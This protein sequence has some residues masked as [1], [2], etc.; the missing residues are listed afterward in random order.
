MKIFNEK[1][2]FLN[3]NLKTMG[4]PWPSEFGKV[5]YLFNKRQ[6]LRYG[7]FKKHGIARY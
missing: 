3:Y 6:C 5:A 7:D 2:F 4:Q 1:K